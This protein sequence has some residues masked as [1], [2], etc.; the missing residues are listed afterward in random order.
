MGKYYLK[1]RQFP[2]HDGAPEKA[3]TA[4]GQDAAARPDD[5]HFDPHADAHADANADAGANFHPDD[6]HC[7]AHCGDLASGGYGDGVVEDICFSSFP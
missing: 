2:P 1:R 3:T 7:D 4:S 6:P 5:P